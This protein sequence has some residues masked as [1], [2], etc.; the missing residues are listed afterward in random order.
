MGFPVHEAV[1]DLNPCPLQRACPQKILFLV[2][3]S[4]ELDNGR[5]RF[6]GLRCIDERPNDRR[7]FACAIEGL[8]DRHHVGIARSLFEEGHHHVEGFVGVV[9]DD[10]LGANRGEAV[11][12]IFTDAFREARR[13]C[14]ELEVRPVFVNQRVEIPDANEAINIDAHRLMAL[15]HGLKKLFHRGSVAALILQADD[16][17]APPFLDR[18]PV[19]SDQILRFFFQLDVAVPQ[20]A[21][22]NRFFHDETG[23]KKVRVAPYFG[24]ECHVSS[25]LAGQPD[26][27]RHGSRQNHQLLHRLLVRLTHDTEKETEPFVGDERKR[28]GRVERLR[29]EDREDLRQE[30]VSQP[31]FV[32]FWQR[33]TLADHRNAAAA[34]L[35]VQFQ[36]DSLLTSHQ[37]IGMLADRRELLG[38]R[39][40][41]DRPKIDI[42]K[43]LAL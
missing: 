40:P 19:I 9:D 16:S 15:C 22:E 25:I 20:D 4:L 10:I 30:M 23:K 27:T 14:R 33:I 34:Q 3:P 42:L 13:E 38:W 43:L 12:A 28:M 7:L 29:R 36:P 17:A 35:T 37:G 18:A 5:H 41:I 26:E 8:L 11:P 6:A 39:Q 1:D 32:L 21:E 31:K 24:L 2:E